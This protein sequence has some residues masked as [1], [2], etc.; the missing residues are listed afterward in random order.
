MSADASSR[1][2]RAPRL[3][4]AAGSLVGA[5][6][7]ALIGLAC[8]ASP[9]AHTEGELRRIDPPRS[10][11]GLYGAME[12]CVGRSG[13][14]ERVNWYSADRIVD[15][16]GVERSGIWLVAEGDPHGIAV[17][18]RIVSDKDAA[19]IV[20][21]HEVIHEILQLADHDD[22]IWCRC[23]PVPSRFDHCD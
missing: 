16:R 20:V 19:R 4:R 7:L 8:D 12:L 18:R 22:P 9:S 1:D 23:D 21:Q 17:L 6:A 2:H 15:K 5:L 13:D 10:W 11:R 3:R 14:F